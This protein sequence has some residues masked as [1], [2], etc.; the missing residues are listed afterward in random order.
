MSKQ[1]WQTNRAVAKA[2]PIDKICRVNALEPLTV[3]ARPYNSTPRAGGG[4]NRNHDEDSQYYAVHR[5]CMIVHAYFSVV[6]IMRSVLFTAVS[7]DAA[8]NLILSS[9]D[10]SELVNLSRRQTA[11]VKALNCNAYCWKYDGKYDGK[12]RSKLS[13]LHVQAYRN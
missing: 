5:L 1:P 3:F 6:D 2:S 7:R 13:T 10:V 11:G 12:K 8:S 9:Y 4:V